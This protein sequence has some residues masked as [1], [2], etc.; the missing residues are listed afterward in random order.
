MSQLPRCSCH[1]ASV[2]NEACDRGYCHGGCIFYDTNRQIVF[3]QSQI[4]K[5]KEMAEQIQSLQSQVT[6]LEK[7]LEMARKDI[8]ESKKFF[9]RIVD[10]RNPKPCPWCDTKDVLAQRAIETLKLLEAK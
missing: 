3:F 4:L 2:C 1:S 5:L 9:K 6:S 10:S 8:H 7:K